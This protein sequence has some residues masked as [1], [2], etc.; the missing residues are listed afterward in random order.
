VGQS[1]GGGCVSVLKIVFNGKATL[2]DDPPLGRSQGKATTQSFA[3]TSGNM[4]HNHRSG[5]R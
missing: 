2:F 5:L 4:I 3:R 1:E